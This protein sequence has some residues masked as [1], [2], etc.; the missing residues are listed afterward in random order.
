[1]QT[2][3]NF[4]LRDGRI[5][6]T[7]R[8]LLIFN[9]LNSSSIIKQVDEDGQDEILSRGAEIKSLITYLQTNPNSPL[10]LLN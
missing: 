9:G 1:M 5:L 3:Q 8:I 4:S 6:P 10:P 7:L 2:I